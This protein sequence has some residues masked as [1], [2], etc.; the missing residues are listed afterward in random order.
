M[1]EIKIEV[2]FW[3][4]NSDFTKSIKKHYTTID[5][6]IDGSDTFDYCH[7]DIVAKRQFT[8]LNDVKSTDV[9]EGD[10]IDINGLIIGN[11]HEAQQR[12]SDLVIPSIT[13]RDWATAYKE[14]LD[15]GLDH[16]K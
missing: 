7:V 14:G 8:G 4:H 9:Y 16:A 3:V 12:E 1:R 6:L 15:R 10:T 2:M 13:S 11:I 5:R